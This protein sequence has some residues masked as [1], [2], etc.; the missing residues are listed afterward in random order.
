MAA[1]S[2]RACCRSLVSVACRE[3]GWTPTHF[4]V[5][6]RQQNEKVGDRYFQLKIPPAVGDWDELDP[7]DLPNRLKGETMNTLPRDAIG[8]TQTAQ[9]LAPERDLAWSDAEKVDR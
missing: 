8:Q 3:R 7:L 4:F 1:A 6:L 5:W 9:R 2:I